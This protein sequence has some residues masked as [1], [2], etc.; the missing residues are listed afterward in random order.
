LDLI[1]TVLTINVKDTPIEGGKKMGIYSC[2]KVI[3]KNEGVFGLYKGWF[4]T[5]VVSINF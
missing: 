1:R 3:L 2:G 4:A 5:M